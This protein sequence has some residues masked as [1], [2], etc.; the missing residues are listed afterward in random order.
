MA[1]S[2]YNEITIPWV[3][4]PSYSE[5][6]SNEPIRDL[7]IDVGSNRDIS[8]MQFFALD[9]WGTSGAAGDWSFRNIIF[10]WVNWDKQKQYT[11]T[12]MEWLWTTTAKI[13]KSYS[14]NTP[15]SNV[16]Y[17]MPWKIFEAYG[18]FNTSTMS[19]RMNRTGWNIRYLLWWNDIITSASPYVSWFNASDTAVQVRIQYSTS[20]SER[21]I[22]GV[23]IKVY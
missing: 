11:E 4:A 2:S 9:I 6:Y 18:N 20:A 16:I 14:I 7:Q 10:T 17:V 5:G 1:E 15:L 21:P 23:F 3:S 13:S 22:F 19:V 12:I 8:T